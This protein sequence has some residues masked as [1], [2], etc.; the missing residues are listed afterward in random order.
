[1]CPHLRG[2]PEVRLTRFP[3]RLVLIPLMAEGRAGAPVIGF[4]Q[5]CGVTRTI[6]RRWRLSPPAAP[7]R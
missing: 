7:V 5:L 1:M 4:I 6:D 3:E 2:D